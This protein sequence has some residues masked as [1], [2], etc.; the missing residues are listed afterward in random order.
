MRYLYILFLACLAYT[1]HI[2]PTHAQHLV[3][4][5]EEALPVREQA[6]FLE[7]KT[8]KLTLEDIL[9]PTQQRKFIQAPSKIFTRTANPYSYWFKITVRNQTKEKAWIDV[10][11]IMPWYIDYFV[12]ENGAYKK[13][14]T[15]G[16]LRPNA[17][18]A[19]PSNTF[20][21][22]L[23]T[24]DTLQ[25]VYIRIQ[26]QR[27]LEV[28]ILIGT[29]SALHQHKDKSNM[30]ASAFVGLML[31]VILY[32]LFIYF[33]LRDKLYLWYVAYLFSAI[34]SFTFLNNYPLHELFLPVA[35]KNGVHSYAFFA[36][37][38]G[39]MLF[40]VIFLILFLQPNRLLNGIMW[41]F[42]GLYVGII[43]FLAFF[44]LVPYYLLARL[45]QSLVFLFGLFL[46]SMSFY[47]WLIRKNENAKFFAMGWFGL[48]LSMITYLLVMNN[49]LPHNFF[50]RNIIFVGCAAQAV[51]FSLA[52]ANRINE[53]QQEARKAQEATFKAIEE[54]AKLIIQQNETL[55]RQVAERTQELTNSEEELKQHLEELTKTQSQ[56][57]F[58]EKMASLGQLVAS[59]A[60]EI[61]TPLGA[62]RSSANNVLKSLPEA[63]LHLPAFVMSLPTEETHHFLALLERILEQKQSLMSSREARKVRNQITQY[64]EDLQIERAS[65]IAELLV[66]MGLYD[67]EGFENIWKAPNVYDYIDMLF[68]LVMLFRSSENILTATDRASKIIFA[69]KNFSRQDHSNEKVSTNLNE[70]LDTVLTI[71]HSQMKHGIEVVRQFAT[72]PEIHGYPDELIQVWTNLIHNA[73][74]AMA[75][76]GV[77][78]VSTKLQDNQAVVSIQ[79]TG[80]GIPP[81]IQDKIF[82]AFFTTKPQ[83]EGSGL[84]LDIVKKIVEKHAGKIWFETEAGKGTTFLVQIPIA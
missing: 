69:L 51:I 21:L 43:P 11:S 45:N 54:N 74:H 44:E 73:I 79:D 41:G 83:G 42:L 62:I 82:N 14:V 27:N 28:P 23:H 60:H 46:M 65:D 77:L 56:L 75:G 61:N 12:F 13:K 58:S 39:N 40:M 63:L 7:D 6:Y 70:S 22:P 18:K 32:H 38:N 35:W 59:V 19:Y 76:K 1:W 80:A 36:L 8:N 33:S 29:T 84:G 67:L 37:Q 49:M 5:G 26:T 50:L 15:T 68:R 17:Q 9:Q 71:Y 47:L 52:L 34:F 81:E 20:W 2:F 48:I 53:L 31:F 55:E 25:T 72:L 3:L 66:D 78:T 24:S 57:V 16:S 10:G 30:M 4:A 64:L